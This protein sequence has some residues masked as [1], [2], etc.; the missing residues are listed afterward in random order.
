VSDHGRAHAQL[1]PSSAERWISCPASVGLIASLDR[2]D[3]GGSAFAAEGTWAHDEAEARAGLHFGLIDQHAYDQ[4]REAWLAAGHLN[5]WDAAEAD[6]HVATYVAMLQDIHDSLSAGGERVTVR[7]EIRVQTGVPGSWGTADA[8]LSTVRKIAVVD[9]KY[10]K[11]HRV[12]ARE[13]PQ[14]M[15]YAVGVVEILDPLGTIEDVLIGICQPRVEGGITTWAIPAASLTE[16]RDHEVMEAAAESQRPDARFGPSEEACRWCPASGICKPRMEYVT[17]R[18]FGDPNAMDMDELAEQ[19]KRIGEVRDWCNAVEKEGL[20]QTYTN[21]KTLPGLKVVL[22][23]GK[24]S[25]KAADKPKAIETLVAAGYDKGKVT[26]QPPE[27]TQTL[28]ALDKVVGGRERL[29]EVL[30]PLLSKGDGSPSLVPED[31]PR[32]AITPTTQAAKDF[33]PE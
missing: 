31:D 4:H 30:G 19:V 17:R 10:G 20:I 29:A 26:R 11:G 28:S 32:E 23:G 8:A 14:A 2:A 15:L 7:L 27:D 25:I 13:N 1:S 22:S 16:W 21:G 24:A 9:F 18:D 12:Y 6:E 33:Q 3:D 5:G